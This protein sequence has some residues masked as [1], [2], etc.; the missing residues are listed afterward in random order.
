M[1]Y[2]NEKTGQ[3]QNEPGG[4]YDAH[5]KPIP[6]SQAET[7]TDAEREQIYARN[8]SVA[9][10]ITGIL[11]W[12]I[13]LTWNWSRWVVRHSGAYFTA[14]L[15]FV[16][17]F[18]WAFWLFCSIRDPDGQY[19]VSGSHL[20]DYAIVMGI[21]FWLTGCRYLA[22]PKDKKLEIARKNKQERKKAK[23]IG[24]V[25]EIFCNPN[26]SLPLSFWIGRTIA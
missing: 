1:R 19:T 5:I 25:N 13:K 6:S 10:L 4:I 18:L 7:Y 22:T 21:V 15:V 14:S 16:F 24:L 26:V 2:Y 20:L 17:H 11:L 9:S 8:A 12:Y 23:S 3:V